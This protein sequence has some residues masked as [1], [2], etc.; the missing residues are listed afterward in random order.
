MLA[1]YV[2]VLSIILLLFHG[3]CSELKT[4]LRKDRYFL[5]K[6]RYLEFPEGSNIVF[7]L[8]FV[9]AVMVRKPKGYMSLLECDVPF[10][11]PSATDRPIKKKYRYGRN[12]EFKKKWIKVFERLGIDGEACVKRIICE[13]ESIVRY[14]KLS[15]ISRII[16]TLFSEYFESER[17]N[18]NELEDCILPPLPKILMKILRLETFNY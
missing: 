2:Y 5:R 4:L 7:T 3:H 15:I 11:L 1:A 17:C 10:K 12:A 6:K 8:S 18:P 14:E 13:A 16:Q 9:K